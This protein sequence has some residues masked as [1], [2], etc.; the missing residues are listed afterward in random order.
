MASTNNDSN[1]K[2]ATDIGTQ[3]FRSMKIKFGDETIDG[4]EKEEDGSLTSI[5]PSV[6]GW[7]LLI[8]LAKSR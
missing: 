3:L 8:D 4:L 2:W 7:M 5:E 1:I 6:G